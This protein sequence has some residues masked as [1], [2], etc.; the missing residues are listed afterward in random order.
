MIA[1]Q[2]AKCALDGFYG[3]GFTDGKETDGSLVVGTAVVVVS[4]SPSPAASVLGI[5][6]ARAVGAPRR[7]PLRQ[8]HRRGDILLD[9]GGVPHGWDCN[10]DVCGAAQG[11]GCSRS[12]T[13]SPSSVSSN[14]MA[15]PMSHAFDV[16]V[17]AGTPCGRHHRRSYGHR[18][19]PW[20][21]AGEEKG[22]TSTDSEALVIDEEAPE[23]RKT[24]P[25][26]SSFSSRV[27]S[28]SPTDQDMPEISETTKMPAAQ[29]VKRGRPDSGDSGAHAVD[30]L[31]SKKPR[32]VT[33]GA[34]KDTGISS[35]ESPN[36]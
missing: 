1:E 29:D 35:V 15:P 12:R 3:E 31:P 17:P 7:R 25:E 18:Y 2:R 9:A 33:P 36:N 8:D 6:V 10:P 11:H 21:T 30:R 14:T 22:G 4:G 34:T 23:D 32:K 24:F 26:S 13:G 5:T 27:S 20:S 28:D 16:T 19:G